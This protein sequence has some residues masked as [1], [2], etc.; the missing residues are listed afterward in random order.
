MI[1]EETGKKIKQ[2]CNKGVGLQEV[3]EEI[4][5]AQS[6]EELGKIYKQHPEMK[7]KIYPLI[8]KRKEALE[9]TTIINQ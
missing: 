7:D 3:Q 5:K 9:D 6:R 1:S 8:L 4:E 2:W